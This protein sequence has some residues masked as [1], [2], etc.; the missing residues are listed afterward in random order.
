MTVLF[1]SQGQVV[2][3]QPEQFE[4][5]VATEQQ[6]AMQ[7]L[8][9]AMAELTQRGAKAHRSAMDTVRVPVADLFVVC[10]A[11]YAVLQPQE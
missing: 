5:S 9:R 10:Q 2:P 6:Q 11:L 4:A 7:R 8:A 1:D 3:P